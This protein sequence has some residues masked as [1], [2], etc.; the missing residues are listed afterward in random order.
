[1]ISL[2]T[3]HPGVHRKSNELAD[4]VGDLQKFL[5]G[6]D[7]LTTERISVD[8]NYGPQ[9]KRFVEE[10]QRQKRIVADG[11]VGPQTWGHLLA[12]GFRP[13]EYTEDD[14]GYEVHS[15]RFSP[16]WP[17][18]PKGLYPPD[19]LSLFGEGLTYTPDPLPGVPEY[20]AVNS[21]WIRENITSVTIPQLAAVQGA[22][23]SCEVYF[24]KLLVRQLKAFFSFVEQAGKLDL[25]KSWR[26]S[27]TTRFIRGRND[28]L[29]NHTF[30]SAFDINAAWNGFRRLPALVGR[31]G[32]VRELAAIAYKLGFYWGGWYNDGMHFEA[33][34]VMT[35]AQIEK[36]LQ[37][38]WEGNA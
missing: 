30:G 18:K 7:L 22:P 11:L 14:A 25:I 12:D 4:L 2:P 13:K 36:A 20:V 38:L 21:D 37:E 15:E 9:T 16:N 6:A 10:Y 26:G 1:M 5:L 29:S 33:F 28:K 8:E 23:K 35:E 19:G 31:E 3:L 32:S 34:K 24:N 27:W 17:P